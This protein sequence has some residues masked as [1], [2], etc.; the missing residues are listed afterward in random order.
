MTSL[1]DRAYHV[2]MQAIPRSVGAPIVCERPP[3]REVYHSIGDATGTLT[4]PEGDVHTVVHGA[5][6]AR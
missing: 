1:E 2:L 4:A 5:L 3:G 6:I